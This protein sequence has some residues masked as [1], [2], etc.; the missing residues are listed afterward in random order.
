MKDGKVCYLFF[1][2]AYDIKKLPFEP[3][4]YYWV[5]ED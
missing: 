4:A 2:G 1:L 3:D 5:E